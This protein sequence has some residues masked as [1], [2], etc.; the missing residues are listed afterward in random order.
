MRGFY[1]RKRGTIFGNVLRIWGL[2][3]AG[4][5]QVVVMEWRHVQV[6]IYMLRNTDSGIHTQCIGSG[7]SGTTMPKKPRSIVGAART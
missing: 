2:R 1:T 3:L 4:Q 7:G 6:E 5:A